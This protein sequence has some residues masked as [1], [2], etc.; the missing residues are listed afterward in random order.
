MCGLRHTW[1]CKGI[2][3]SCVLQVRTSGIV[4]RS[5]S[6]RRRVEL[7]FSFNRQF[8]PH[9]NSSCVHVVCFAPAPSNGPAMG[10][11]GLPDL[12][13]LTNRESM[14][15]MPIMMMKTVMNTIMII[16]LMRIRKISRVAFFYDVLW[17]PEPL[18]TAHTSR[19][20]TVLLG[21][22][23]K[24][25]YSHFLPVGAGNAK[26][27]AQSKQEHRNEGLGDGSAPVVG[28]GLR[29]GLGLMEGRCTRL[30][31]NMRMMTKTRT[32]TRTRTRRTRTRK[33]KMMMMMDDD[34]WWWMMMDDD[35]WWWM[36]MDDDD[37]D[38]DDDDDERRRK[39]KR[40]RMM[41]MMM[42]RTM[43]TRTRTRT[44]TKTK[45]MMMMM[46]MMEDDGGWEWGWGWGWG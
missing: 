17:S 5:G 26:E 44:T 34:G 38:V 36:M 9:V 18:S 3:T 12:T 16:R 15:M 31:M 42:M 28:P 33:K 41:M 35:G 20:W 1:E 27:M 37:D 8:L 7:A 45:M 24:R 23:R 30:A 4:E 11:Q 46:M 22:G 39:R 32:R 43:R 21:F 10:V 19:F 29:P 13:R 40:K 14:I 2:Q 25:F 6:G